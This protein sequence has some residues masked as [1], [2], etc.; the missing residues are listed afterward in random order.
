MHD[1]VFEDLKDSG[2]MGCINEAGLGVPI[3][4]WLTQHNGASNILYESRCRYHKDTQPQIS[5]GISVSKEMGTSIAWGDHYHNRDA[6]YRLGKKPFS[7]CVTG[8][9]KE[10]HERGESHAWV[11][12]YHDDGVYSYMHFR[13]NKGFGS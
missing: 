2:Y 10:T 4:N 8:A 1:K 5:S 13:L 6:I 9:F 12:L 3:T 7:L 11:V